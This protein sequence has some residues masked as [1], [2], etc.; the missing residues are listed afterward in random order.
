MNDI[1]GSTQKEVVMA[2]LKVIPHHLPGRPD[3]NHRRAVRIAGLLVQI[4]W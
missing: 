1:V 4:W 2:C 3:G